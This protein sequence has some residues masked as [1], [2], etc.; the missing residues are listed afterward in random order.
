M[1]FFFIYIFLF[2]KRTKNEIYM[3]LKKNVMY[4]LFR[5]IRSPY[6]G[7]EGVCIGEAC[8]KWM[9]NASR[10]AVTPRQS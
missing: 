8:G 3:N 6:A 2:K 10:K 5:A 1:Y 4:A 7:N 9:V